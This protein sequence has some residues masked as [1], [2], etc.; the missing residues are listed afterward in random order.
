MHFST[1]TFLPLFS[2]VIQL[3]SAHFTVEYP[4]W[5]G[6]SFAPTAS[7]WIFPC[8]NVSETTDINNRTAWSHEGGSLRL[9]AGHHWALTYVNLGIGTNVSA[10]N[11]SLV[12]H[13]NQT[14]NGT[15][16]LKETGKANLAAGLAAAGLDAS[17]AEG[18]EA[19]L[20]IIQI[21]T[22][23]AA[24]YN[25][26]DIKFSATAALLAD[27]QCT[28][29]TAVG[30]VGI[31][32][33]DATAAQSPSGTATGGAAAT[34]T[35]AAANLAYSSAGGVVAAAVLGAGMMIL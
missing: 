21:S 24:L 23:G 33:A 4:Y 18:L 9:H 29:S 20:Q 31:L 7:Q 2:T 12:D 30:G 35:G 22:T 14:G 1:C 27:D 32:N 34:S 17:S 19:S 16:C 28:N 6:S 5:R 10:F 13:F 26:A 25:C 3:A 8:A 11:I 15:F